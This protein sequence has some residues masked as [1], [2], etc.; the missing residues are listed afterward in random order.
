[1][2]SPSSGI[3]ELVLGTANTLRAYLQFFRDPELQNVLRR[4]IKGK[5]KSIFREVLQLGLYRGRM[6][7]VTLRDV[8]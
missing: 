6:N 7:V 3:P 2:I 1:M 4:H 8:E 5:E